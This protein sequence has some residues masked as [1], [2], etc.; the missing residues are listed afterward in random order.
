MGPWRR[1][2]KLFIQSQKSGKLWQLLISSMKDPLPALNQLALIFREFIHLPI[3]K[4]DQD[5]IS[6]EFADRRQN[7]DSGRAVVF[8]EFQNPDPTRSA[9]DQTIHQHLQI[10]SSL[11]FVVYYHPMSITPDTSNQPNLDIS[12][13]SFVSSRGELRLILRLLDPKVDLVWM[14]RPEVAVHFLPTV[15]SITDARILYYTHDLHF[16]RMQLE[17]S[18]KDSPQIMREANEMMRVER[19]IFDSVNLV[20]SPNPDETTTIR[21]MSPTTR[22]ETV[23]AYFFTKEEVKVRPP[24]SF[25]G[26]KNLVFLGGFSHKPNVDAAHFLVEKVLPLI[27]LEIPDATLFIAGSATSKEIFNLSRTGVDVL[28]QIDS[29]EELFSTCRLFIAPLHYGAGI[30][31]KVVQALRCGLPVLASEIAAEGLDWGQYG[32]GE[33]Y[34]RPE[35]FAQAAVHLIRNHDAC[36]KLSVDGV[37]M[38][39]SSFTFEKAQMRFAALLSLPLG[40]DKPFE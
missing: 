28:G 6:Q 17:S 24:T 19:G 20:F 31:G 9:G 32:S 5:S 35:E 30:K 22:A 8:L 10:L 3:S 37:E 12:G 33:V 26:T 34:S 21:A 38:V 11:G 18:Y 36:H 13:V 7:S 23:P 25:E 40:G 39:N 27:R 15:R 1:I 16:R 29:I 4:R 14:A 2:V